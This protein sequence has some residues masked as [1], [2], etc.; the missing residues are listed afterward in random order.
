MTTPLEIEVAEQQPALSSRRRRTLIHLGLNFVVSWV[1]FDIYAHLVPLRVFVD[2]E[3]ALDVAAGLVIIVSLSC[4]FEKVGLPGWTVLVPFYNVAMVYRV[5]G[6]PSR[7]AAWLLIPIF[8]IYWYIRLM[9]E[10][11]RAFGGD[12]V[13]TVI[14]VIC[15][16]MGLPQLAF[17][18]RGV[19]QLAPPTAQT[20]AHHTVSVHM[21]PA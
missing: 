2:T 17:S 19:Y 18:R 10:L 16:Y 6:R 20:S 11:S 21:A 3:I 13:F 9:H 15:P 5:V 12:S 7:Q 14:L 8:N 4:L 1:V